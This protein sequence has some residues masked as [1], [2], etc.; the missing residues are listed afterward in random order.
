MKGLEKARGYRW[1]EGF[2]Q[3]AHRYIRSLPELRKFVRMIPAERR[4][5]AVQAGG[6]CGLW[7]LE[8]ARHF[9]RVYTCEPD[10]SNFAALAANA[11]VCES[12]FAFRAFLGAVEAPRALRRNERNSGGHWMQPGVPGATPVLALDAL[13]LERCDAIVLDCE[14]AELEALKGARH[15][16]AESRPW[17]LIEVRG[18]IE[19]KLGNSTTGELYELLRELQYERHARLHSDE[20]WA[21]CKSS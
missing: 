20:V 8:L 6:H 7:P 16:I 10:A 2:G 13:M 5:V 12:L 14:G 11:G 9:A 17:I 1:P 19:K 15:T 18:H 4:C 21:P 3:H